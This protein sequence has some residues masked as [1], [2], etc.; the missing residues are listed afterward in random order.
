[1]VSRITVA[2]LSLALLAFSPTSIE[3]GGDKLGKNSI[4][5]FTV[6]D[7]QAEMEL[8]K[9]SD[10]SRFMEEPSIQATIERLIDGFG[11]MNQ[12]QMEVDQVAKDNLQFVWGHLTRARN[13]MTGEFVMG[14]GYRMDPNMGMPMPDLI[15]DFHGP[16]DFTEPHQKMITMIRDLAS[17]EGG[18]QV[19]L[20]TFSIGDME[21]S[22]IEAMPGVGFFI[23]HFEGHHMIG[24]NKASMESY[25]AEGDTTVGERFNSTRIYQLASKHLKRGSS[26][27]F[28]NMDPIWNLIPMMDMFL[29]SPVAGGFDEGGVED[30]ED[31]LVPSKIIGALGLEAM[32]G[33]SYRTYYADGGYGMDGV[34]GVDGRPGVLAILP[35]SNT[36][37]SVPDFVPD[38][39][40]TFGIFNLEISKIFDIVISVGSVIGETDPEEMAA[41]IESGLEMM[42]MQ[43]GVDLMELVDSLSGTICTY[44]KTEDSDSP[45]NPMALMMGVGAQIPLVIGAKIDDRKPWENMLETMGSPEMMGAA[46]KKEE[47]LGRDLYSF[48]PLG[49]VPPEFAGQGPSVV[50]AL[51]LEGD[52][53]L[54]ANAIE[55]VQAA[56][57]VIDGEGEERFGSGER[58]SAILSRVKATQGVNLSLTDVGANLS[59]AADI[60]RPLL[61]LIPLI[62]PDLAQDESMLFLFD[63]E[64][65]PESELLRKYFGWT[66]ARGSVVE[67]GFRSYNFMEQVTKS[68][69][70]EE[71]KEE[72]P[73]GS[74]L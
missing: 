65:I 1:M 9:S 40:S 30:I 42:K 6:D 72:D 11:A 60:F 47:F 4:V 3:A 39:C 53:L 58:T 12:I 74:Q 18:E 66:A 13:E 38:N 31:A 19:P 5:V 16:V 62:A 48:N 68:S 54:F 41:E 28:F 37:I 14:V 36:D 57:R 49:D 64:N 50:P 63:P 56:I 43:T 59:Q 32:S 73:R 23:G 69:D 8:S 45:A 46:L 22:G 27:F 33:L 26:Q 20:R 71:K 2:V 55:D 25:L 44:T 34:F 61:G 15:I 7:W 29:S 24:T 21:F 35:Q 51:C 70:A 17:G 52:W 67:G 10:M